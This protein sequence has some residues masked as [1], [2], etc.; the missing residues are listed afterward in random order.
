MRSS[1]SADCLNRARMRLTT[2]AAELASRMMRSTVLFARSIFG[3]SADEPALAG[4]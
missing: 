3:G 2:S 1:L 4:V